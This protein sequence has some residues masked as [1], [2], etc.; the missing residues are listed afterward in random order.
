MEPFIRLP[1]EMH[2]YDFPED[3]YE[4]ELPYEDEMANA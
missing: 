1:E 4:P 3:Y 2:G